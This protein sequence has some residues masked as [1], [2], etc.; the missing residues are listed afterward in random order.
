MYNQDPSSRLGLRLRAKTRTSG[1]SDFTPSV[2]CRC[3]SYLR[4]R[5]AVTSTTRISRRWSRKKAKTGKRPLSRTICSL[6]FRFWSPFNLSIFL[7]RHS[8]QPTKCSKLQPLQY[9]GRD[10]FAEFVSRNSANSVKGRKTVLVSY[11]NNN[12][13]EFI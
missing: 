7:G 4:S 10:V 13:G 11:N 3:S 12:N 6:F 9:D 2:W 5:N 8:C 1:D